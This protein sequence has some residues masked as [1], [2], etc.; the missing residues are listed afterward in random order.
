VIG[1]IILLFYLASMRLF[2]YQFAI[3]LMEVTSTMYDLHFTGILINF[4]VIFWKA[5]VNLKNVSSQRQ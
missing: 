3:Y 4:F 2:G 5:G 1:V